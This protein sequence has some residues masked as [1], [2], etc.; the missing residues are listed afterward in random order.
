MATM[1]EA[2]R[3]FQGAYLRTFYVLADLEPGCWNL[4]LEDI[5]GRRGFL[6]DARTRQPRSFKT[7]DA[8]ITAANE[9][10]FEVKALA[11][12]RR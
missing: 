5:N 8:A 3:D 4:D 11:L 7:A 6:V 10:G 2:K 12:C 1:A 9:I